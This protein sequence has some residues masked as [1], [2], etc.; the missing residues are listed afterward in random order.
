MSAFL[1]Q[2]G[3]LSSMATG[4][5]VDSTSL[6]RSGSSGVSQRPRQS[7]CAVCAASRVSPPAVGAKYGR[8][9][10]TL[11]VCYGAHHAYV[12]TE[13]TRE[14]DVDGDYTMDSIE[15]PVN[16]LECPRLMQPLHLV[17]TNGR[18][19]RDFLTSPFMRSDRSFEPRPQHEPAQ[20]TKSSHHR[21]HVP[22][23]LLHA[24]I[25]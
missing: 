22:H 23:H 18:R 11:I 8:P 3:H 10:L 24:C 12:I 1:L 7:K 5:R 2:N 19:R 21:L 6:P 14:K 25:G 9:R 4:P 16:I 13:K 20:H 15:R 17:D